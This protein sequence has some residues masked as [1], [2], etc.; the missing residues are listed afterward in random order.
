M[1]NIVEETAEDVLQFNFRSLIPAIVGKYLPMEEYIP[2]NSQL[3]EST[4]KI[5]ASGKFKEASTL[6][7]L[8]SST[9]GYAHV[10][11][12][13]DMLYTW[14]MT[15]K[16]TDLQGKEIKGLTVSNL[17]KHSMIEKIF[18]SKTISPEKKKE[19]FNKL[20]EIDKSDMLGRTQKYCEA[21]IPDLEAKKEI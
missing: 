9:I 14:F 11:K 18:T 15:D 17:R 5:L 16:I 2:M 3:F 6:E 4:L 1:N 20:A 10:D 12:H 7:L 13:K 21:C 19:A 8:L